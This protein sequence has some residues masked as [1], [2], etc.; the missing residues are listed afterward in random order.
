[1]LLIYLRLL[2]VLNKGEYF[3]LSGDRW[4]LPGYPTATIVGKSMF[5]MGLLKP[6]EIKYPEYV[7]SIQYYTISDYG[8]EQLRLGREWWRSL[9]IF[10]KILAHF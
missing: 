5:E 4:I 10:Q 9:S 1:M 2:S 6:V 3:I 8:K 7:D